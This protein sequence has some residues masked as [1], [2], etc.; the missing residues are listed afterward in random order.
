MNEVAHDHVSA[1]FSA[2]ESG[3]FRA[4]D[5]TTPEGSP[6]PVAEPSLPDETM[7][8]E[9]RLARD[10]AARPIGDALDKAVDLHGDALKRLARCILRVSDLIAENET[11]GDDEPELTRL[12]RDLRRVRRE[13]QSARATLR[14]LHQ[15]EGSLEGRGLVFIEVFRYGSEEEKADLR[16]RFAISP[17]PR[18]DE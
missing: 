1:A 7:G 2:P 4:A 13:V 12:A 18:V 8:E 6:P 9:E 16:E 3:T 10:L 17:P 15:R 14:D 5:D 11:D